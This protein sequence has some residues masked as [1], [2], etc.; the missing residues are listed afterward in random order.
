MH[1]FINCSLITEVVDNEKKQKHVYM[2]LCL[3]CLLVPMNGTAEGLS[4]CFLNSS[5]H[6]HGE[7]IKS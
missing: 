5:G 2:C 1:K 4:R 6:A 7:Q 3:R